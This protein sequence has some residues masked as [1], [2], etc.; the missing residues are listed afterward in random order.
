MR[1][2]RITATVLILAAY[3]LA[4]NMKDAQGNSYPTV[5]I[6]NQVW[7]AKNMNVKTKE[8]F[9]YDENKENC[10]K[11]GRLY[12]L[13]AAQ[14]VCPTGW[15]LPTINDYA[16][17][18]Q[19]S[20]FN[21]GDFYDS[22]GGIGVSANGKK[23]FRKL[24]QTAGFWSSNIFNNEVH[25]L[26]VIKQ[27]NNSNKISITSGQKSDYALFSVRCIQKSKN[28]SST[29]KR[30]EEENLSSV[31]VGKQ[32]WMRKNMN[33]DIDGSICLGG[34]EDFCK[35]YGRLYTKKAAQE[36]CPTGW[37]LPTKEEFQELLYIAGDKDED[38]SL[39]LRSKSWDNGSDLFGLSLFPTGLRI[40]GTSIYVNAGSFWSSSE[41]YSLFI[42]PF[43]SFLDS[44]SSINSSSYM[45]V[46]CIKDES[47]EFITSQSQELANTRK[48]LESTL[49]DINKVQEERQAVAAEIKEKNEEIK[50]ITKEGFK[51]TFKDPRDG[52]TYE[53]VKIGNQTWMAKNLDF[54]TNG[55][56]CFKNDKSMCK[57]Y[58]RLYTW[59]AASSACP[60]G[61][62]LPN[63]NEWTTLWKTVG[64]TSYAGRELKSETGWSKRGNG[65]DTYGFS[66]LPAGA[67]SAGL[68]GYE[69]RFAFFWSA[70]TKGGSNAYFWEFY[71][72]YP[73]VNRD[74]YNKYNA[75]SVRCIKSSNNMVSPTDQTHTKIRSSNQKEDLK[76][77]EKRNDKKESEKSDEKKESQS[78]STLK[79]IFLSMALGLGYH[80]L[81]WGLE[82]TN[83]NYD[84]T[85]NG[86]GVAKDFQLKFGY[87]TSEKLILQGIILGEWSDVTFS[88][89][90]YE[91]NQDVSELIVGAG[92]TYYLTENWN[93]GGSIGYGKIKLNTYSLEAL[94]AQANVGYD[95]WINDNMAIGGSCNLQIARGVEEIT[96][97]ERMIGTLKSISFLL[98]FTFLNNP[99][100]HD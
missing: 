93:V 9:C 92:V 47:T 30:A 45:A 19:S 60:D 67:Q 28:E 38:R 33:T 95:Y 79:K 12:T 1:T 99:G 39:I 49:A 42:D 85:M 61:W 8:S 21:L 34:D 73:S 16:N 17:L 100:F 94:V 68:F 74:S 4:A 25:A 11:Y 43:S 15:K 65:T 64:G 58:G 69:G 22:L 81:N 89:R 14:Q 87:P 63:D 96:D 77:Y 53:T 18:L 29:I 62:H 71:H 66:V 51:R 84:D 10:K 50:K 86:T 13:E 83:Y 26:Q 41:M 90:G 35:E 54:N 78:E 2:L 72:D 36:V 97:T 70:S 91:F 7:M 75:Y 76:K 6:G 27:G 40:D 32:E 82:S 52:K 44:P 80:G 55:S 59:D 3:A 57:K 56:F 24:E 5:K 20:N 98:T 46:R 37:H 88:T 48:L 23:I 31:K